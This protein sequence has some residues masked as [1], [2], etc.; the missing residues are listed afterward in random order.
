MSDKPLKPLT[1]LDPMPFGKYGPKAPM[2]ERKLMQDVPA[3]YFHWLWTEGELSKLRAG[4]SAHSTD[5]KDQ[6]DQVADYIKR[7]LSALETEYTNGIWRE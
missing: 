2:R 3:K 6:N 7:N 5:L 1:D 4:I